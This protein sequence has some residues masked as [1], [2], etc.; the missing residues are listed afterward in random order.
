MPEQILKGLWFFCSI[1]CGQKNE[2]DTLKGVV[3]KDLIENGI[4]KANIT[5][6]DE[7]MS[8]IYEKM[9]DIN[10]L[11][12]KKFTSKCESEPYEETEWKITLNGDTVTHSIRKY[13][14]PTKDAEHFL[15]LR[16]YVFNK[17]KNKEE[18]IK[19]PKA[20]GG[21]D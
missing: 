17:V 6:S 5:S 4:A 19:L 12:E 8:K 1:W 13:C 3:I 15:E 2:F 14:D 16:N 21:Y 9:K 7:E 10:V 11:E 18:F 20:K